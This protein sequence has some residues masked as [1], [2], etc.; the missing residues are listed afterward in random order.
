M[1]APPTALARTVLRVA[2]SQVGVSEVPPGSNRGPEVDGYLR[3][4]GLDPE[5]WS[6]PWCAAFVYWCFER[7]CR[8]LGRPNPVG[9]HGIGPALESA[10]L[11][12]G[13]KDGF[14]REIPV[15]VRVQ[16]EHEVGL[17]EQ[18]NQ[19]VVEPRQRRRG[20][21]SWIAVAQTPSRFTPT[22]SVSNR[23]ST[24][25]TAHSGSKRS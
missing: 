2:A 1:S 6:Y 18:W 5:Q 11:E 10:A 7:A 3:A 12:P 9:R 22:Y 21:E 25:A 20:N 14:E 8:E 13:G 15:E 16:L 24:S 17:G 19:G 23:T 4:V